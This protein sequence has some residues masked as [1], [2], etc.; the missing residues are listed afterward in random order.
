M[1]GGNQSLR[2]LARFGYM[3]GIRFGNSKNEWKRAEM[4][5]FCCKIS[6]PTAYT[7]T[8]RYHSKWGKQY[9]PNTLLVP[10]S[11]LVSFSNLPTYSTD[12]DEKPKGI[13][14]RFKEAYKEYGK[15]LVG[16]HAVTSTVWFGSFYY[17]AYS[18][19]DI[20]PLLQSLG[21][22]ER[23]IGTFTK[24]GVGNAAVAY[25]L[26]KIATPARYFVTIG[27][28]RVLVNQLRSRG[29]MEKVPEGSRFRDLASDMRE[30]VK[31][32]MEDRYDK[33]KD[34]MQDTY[35]STKDNLKDKVE[36]WK[37]DVKDNLH[38]KVENV[39][40]KLHSKYDHV[41]DRVRDQYHEKQD[42]IEKAKDDIKGTVEGTRDSMG[43][44]R[45][46]FKSK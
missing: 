43:K 18:G 2:C 33:M 41:K 36:D 23:I 37:D 3:N 28:T 6:T 42:V 15:V 20:V 21:F 19:I 7:S 17:A 24:A 5:S 10:K 22:G 29:Y 12:Q 8:F 27:G 9:E 38:D 11:S 34:K 26:Y 13:I 25:L 14:L 44:L 39:K 45:N 31:D 40:G 1:I 32:K 46:K 35:D 16:V 4:A 30:G